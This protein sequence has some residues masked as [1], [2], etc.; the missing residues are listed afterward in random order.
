[1]ILII[2]RFRIKQQGKM[3]K[4]EKSMETYQKAVIKI[5][6]ALNLEESNSHSQDC[7]YEAADS[8]RIR[9]FLEFY[10]SNELNMAEKRILIKL[11][12]ESY[13]DY[14]EKKDSIPIIRE[15]SKQFWKKRKDYLKILFLSGRVKRRTWRILFT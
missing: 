5:A 13:N 9:D 12:L 2:E 8:N 1:M 11:L 15:R 3:E 14:V 10:I 7:E 6:L 4:M